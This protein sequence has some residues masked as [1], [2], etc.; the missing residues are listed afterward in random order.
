MV[1]ID[2]TYMLTAEE[3]RKVTYGTGNTKE[4]LCI[5]TTDNY[6]EGAKA[7]NHA[8]LQ[9][10]GNSRQASWHYQVDD[11]KTYQ[12]FS[13]NHRCWH[14]GSGNNK[15]IA[16][17]ICVDKGSD[18]DKTMR[19]AVQLA[20]KILKDEKIPISKMVQHNYFTGKNCP[21]DIRDGKGGWTW[22][23]FVAEVK[24]ELNKS[25]VT[26]VSKPNKPSKPT[27]P[28][29]IGTIKVLVD[30]LNYYNGPRWSKPTGTVDKNTVLTIVGKVK[31]DGAYQYKTIVGNYITA[32]SKYVKFTAK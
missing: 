17:E 28:K 3:A 25:S 1:T 29:V 18:W 5:H 15:S 13:N 11:I 6:K 7:L 23:K 21:R 30:D 10:N 8:L 32:S 2:K 4:F 19:N 26:Q 12:S 14:A 24:K 16:I 22:K 20:A 31:V 9:K 27:Q